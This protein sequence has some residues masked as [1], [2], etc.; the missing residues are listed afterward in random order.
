M[1]DESTQAREIL[2]Q[3]RTVRPPT[4]PPKRSAVPRPR[5]PRSPIASGSR[6]PGRPR[7]PR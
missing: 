7:K 5:S 4:I 2:G 3:A 1:N 6:P